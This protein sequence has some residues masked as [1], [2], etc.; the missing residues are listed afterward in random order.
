MDL[1]S[2]QKQGI[3]EAIKSTNSYK[4]VATSSNFAL[5]GDLEKEQKNFTERNF[6]REAKGGKVLL[7]PNTMKDIKQVDLKPYTPDKDQME[8]IEQNVFDYFGVN[9]DILQ[10]KA[11]GDA[12]TAFY[13]GA[14]EPFAIQFSET[15]TSALYS[16]REVSFC[17]EVVATTNRVQYMSFTDKKAYVEGGLD[18]G[19]LTINEAREVYNLPPLPDEQGNRFI[20]RGEYYFI[21]E[22]NPTEE[23]NDNA[24]EE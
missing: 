6:G 24:N 2:I 17:A 12:W 23:D 22:E 7:F 20:A 3:K 5:A 4:F 14:V 16:E 10:N 18:R 1:L 19:I 21:Q 8:L 9:K 13:E 15:M 11:V